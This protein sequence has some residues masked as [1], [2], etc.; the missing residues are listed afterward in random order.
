MTCQVSAG[1]N[2]GEAYQG[3]GL[4]VYGMKMLGEGHSGALTWLWLKGLV[5]KKVGSLAAELWG[6]GTGKRKSRAWKIILVGKRKDVEDVLL[7]SS[8]RGEVD[9]EV[10]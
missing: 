2:I 4:K 5:R 8:R 3:E 7:C 9:T 6:W 1:Q 10:R